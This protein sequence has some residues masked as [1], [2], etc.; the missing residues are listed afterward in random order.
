MFPSDRDALTQTLTL[1]QRDLKNK[2]KLQKK[3]KIKIIL[4]FSL[5]YLSCAE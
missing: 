5:S 4:A 2:N 1:L 3:P